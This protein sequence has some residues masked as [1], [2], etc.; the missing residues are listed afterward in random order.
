MSLNGELPLLSVSLFCFSAK[1]IVWKLL[2]FPSHK[3]DKWAKSVELDIPGKKLG[4][5]F[6]TGT[7]GKSIETGT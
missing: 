7:D 4:G 2:G 5:N 1:R 3:D 6:E